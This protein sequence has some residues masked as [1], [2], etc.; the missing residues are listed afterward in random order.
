LID[1]CSKTGVEIQGRKTFAGPDS[2]SVKYN[3]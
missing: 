2:I 3:L 1:Y